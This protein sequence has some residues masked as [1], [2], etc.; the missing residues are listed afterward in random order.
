MDRP[1][2]R[3][4]VVTDTRPGRDPLNVVN[5]AVSVARVRACA[6]ELAVQ[7]RVED[8]VTDRQAYE[9]TVATLAL[10]RPAGVLCLVNDRLQ[11]ALA[12]GAD[13]CHV[14]ADDLPVAVARHVLDAFADG[15]AAAAAAG[16]GVGIPPASGY[17]WRPVLG[18]TSREPATARAA[19][20]DGATYL[21][22]G[23]AYGTTSKEGLPVPIG[24]AGVGAVA[25]AVPGVPV[26]AI[27]GVTVDAVA[28]LLAAGAHGVAVVS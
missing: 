13:G 28:S 5:A 21:G 14:G 24:P 23:P 9:L 22:V 4:H 19:V 8:T 15:V 1:F 18:A 17:R 3:L 6:S 26:I 16:S 12:A 20:A 25:R 11:V 27:G 7:V 10:C 2:P